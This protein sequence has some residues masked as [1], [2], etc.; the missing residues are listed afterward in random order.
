[1]FPPP[2]RRRNIS[3]VVPPCLGFL[4]EHIRERASPEVGQGGHTPRPR[5]QGPGRA[6][7]GCD[8]PAGPLRPPSWLSSS[9]GMLGAPVYSFRQEG[10]QKYGVLTV[11]FPAESRLRRCSPR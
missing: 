6:A 9:Y 4:G 10:L 5:G 11:L 3:S 2:T 8:H 1:L 7:L